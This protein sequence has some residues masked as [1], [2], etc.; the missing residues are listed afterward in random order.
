MGSL[1]LVQGIFPIQESN[2]GF[3]PCRRII[4]QLSY[5]FHLGPLGLWF[6][7]HSQVP[8]TC[9]V[10]PKFQPRPVHLLANLPQVWQGQEAFS[11]ASPAPRPPKLRR[12]PALALTP[13]AEELREQHAGSGDDGGGVMGQATEYVHDEPN[14]LAFFSAHPV[15]I[16]HQVQVSGQIDVTQDLCPGLG[17]EPPTCSR[18]RTAS[19]PYGPLLT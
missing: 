13:V 9:L 4:Y 17:G 12:A 3:L 11:V 14:P 18:T 2:R 15:G 10:A 6:L 1:S 5:P 7:P 19:P 16:G 8:P